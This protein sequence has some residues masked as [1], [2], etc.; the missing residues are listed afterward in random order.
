MHLSLALY[1]L[2]K[3]LTQ[4]LRQCQN[5]YNRAINYIIQLFSN[6]TAGRGR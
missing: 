5:R 2:T 6:S 1:E 3:L 4:L